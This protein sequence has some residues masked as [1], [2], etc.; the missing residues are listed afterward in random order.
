MNWSPTNAEMTGLIHRHNQT[1]SSTT[2]ESEE[3]MGR[4]RGAGQGKGERVSMG[5]FAF[6][7]IKIPPVPRAIR[8][9]PNPMPIFW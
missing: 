9:S 1:C 3:V 8:P 6:F 5:C 7:C 2:E 4:R